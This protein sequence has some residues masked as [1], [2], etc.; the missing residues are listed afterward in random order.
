[1]ERTSLDLRSKR[2][3]KSVWTRRKWGQAKNGVGVGVRPPFSAGVQTKIWWNACYVGCSL[4]RPNKI[5]SRFL[6]SAR[7]SNSCCINLFIF[8]KYR[9]RMERNVHC[10]YVPWAEPKWFVCC[11]SWAAEKEKKLMRN[12]DFFS[13]YLPNLWLLLVCF[14][15]LPVDVTVNLHSASLAHNFSRLKEQCPA[16]GD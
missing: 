5:S 1:M 12:R 14:G 3:T 9:K 2:L 16:S 4:L 7:I 10:P 13:F 15:G 8:F 11:A 6:I